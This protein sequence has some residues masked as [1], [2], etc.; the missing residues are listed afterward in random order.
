MWC[1]WI[2]EQMLGETLFHGMWCCHQIGKNIA[3]AWQCWWGFGYFLIGNHA[4]LHGERKFSYFCHII[5]EKNRK[6]KQNAEIEYSALMKPSNLLDI[7]SSWLLCIST[8]NWRSS[9]TTLTQKAQSILFSDI[10]VAISNR[11]PLPIIMKNQPKLK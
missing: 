10:S 1:N 4:F 3:L 7:T 5:I 8:A 6:W 11:S 2:S 9:S